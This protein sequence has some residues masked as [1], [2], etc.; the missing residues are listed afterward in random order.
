MLR[1]L[2]VA[3]QFLTRLP[4]PTLGEISEKQIG[5]S[6]LYY[7][8]VGLIIG[9]VLVALQLALG[10]APVPLEAALLLVAWIAIT[11]GLHIDGLADS[12]DAWIGGLGNRARTLEIM[13]DPRC[14]PMGVV[15]I[16]AVLIVKFAALEALVTAGDWLA[17]LIAPVLARTALPALFISTAYVRES[18]LGSTLA[19]NIPRNAAIAVVGVTLAAIPFAAGLRGFWMLIVAVAV[20]L[21]LRRAMMARI[22]G[23][24]GDTAGAVVELL[25]TA[26]LV[27]AGLH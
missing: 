12:A 10:G 22:G 23:T 6:M 13:K 1:P 5:H 21:G 26:V 27:V 19:A 2:I 8:L 15:A 11:G 3:I 25:E 20:F 9:G 24:T 14:G 7:P 17:L 18:G 4:V 16:V